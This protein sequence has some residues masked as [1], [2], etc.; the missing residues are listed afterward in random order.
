MLAQPPPPPLP[1]TRSL[2]L[3]TVT[4]SPLT[5]RRMQILGGQLAD[6][7]GGK[8]VLASG[9]ALWSLFTLLTPEAASMGAAPLLAA[10]VLLGVGEGIA[11]P[12]IHSMIA[13][14][15]PQASQSTAVGVVR[16]W[17]GGAEAGGAVG[18]GGA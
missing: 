11:F 5:T 1:P 13:R 8:A 6:R 4:A 14:N 2:S 17:G 15:V 12:S 7:F 10:R 9:V 16:A 18:D 3:P